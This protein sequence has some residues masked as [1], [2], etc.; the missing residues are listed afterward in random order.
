MKEILFNKTT[1]YVFCILIGGFY[2]KN[3]GYK[4]KM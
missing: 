2:F 1:D 3:K 4:F